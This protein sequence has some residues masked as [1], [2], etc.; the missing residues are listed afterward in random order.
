MFIYRTLININLKDT[1]L[2][3]M[4]LSA[5]AKLWLSV[6]AL[7]PDA[8]VKGEPSTVMAFTSEFGQMIMVLGEVAPRQLMVEVRIW[9][10][11]ADPRSI[12]RGNVT[13]NNEA[14]VD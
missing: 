6:V 4:N 2:R 10:G 7:V 1:S 5:G 11:S 8:F 14:L 13:Q 12:S 9:G 3:V